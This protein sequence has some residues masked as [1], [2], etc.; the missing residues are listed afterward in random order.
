MDLDEAL[1]LIEEGLGS[2]IRA[3]VEDGLPG[4]ANDECQYDAALA[5]DIARVVQRWMNR[6]GR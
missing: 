3:H 6:I 4:G 5:K 2:E 1:E